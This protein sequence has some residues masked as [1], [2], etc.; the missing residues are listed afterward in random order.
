MILF[1]IIIASLFYI[2]GVTNLLGACLL[3]I[4]FCLGVIFTAHRL[5]R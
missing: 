4:G 3:I 5:T 2:D 1:T